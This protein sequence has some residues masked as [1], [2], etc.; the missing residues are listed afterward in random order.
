MAEISKIRKNGVDYDIKDATARSATAVSAE[1]NEDTKTVCF[2]NAF[3]EEVFNLDLSGLGGGS[4]AV[5]G[6]LVLSAEELTITE[7]QTGTFTVV[8]DAAPTVNQ[9]VYLAVSDGSRLSV[10]TAT[11][12]FTPDNWEIPQTV[13]VTS[14]EDDDEEDNAITVTLTSTTVDARQVAVAI[15]DNDER[16]EIVTDGLVINMDYTGHVGDESDTITD[17]ASGVSFKNFSHFTKE[18]TGI[19]GPTTYKYLDVVV[20]DAKTAFINKVK[21]TGGFTL[22]TFGTRFVPSFYLPNYKMVMAT[23]NSDGWPSTVTGELVI[24][25]VAKTEV[26]RILQDGNTDRTAVEFGNYTLGNFSRP[27]NNAFING[28]FPYITEFK[29]IV[30]TFSA[31]GQMDCYVNGVK[32]DAPASV[33]NFQAW[34]FD[35]MFGGTWSLINNINTAGVTTTQRIYNRVL[36]AEEVNQNM[37]TDAK[38]LGLTTF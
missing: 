25:T 21:A 9:P 1:Y 17:L 13:T 35:T 3:G 36:T 26:A 38:K 22:E 33:E 7:G 10:S 5:Y 23:G 32:G 19:T 15:M 30:M 2:K 29:H 4:A 31:D 20:D 16:L 28:L 14:L 11:L 12:T 18:E 24:P 8:L 6:N 34:D 37:R 27:M